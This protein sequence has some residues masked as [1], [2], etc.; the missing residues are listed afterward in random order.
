MTESQNQRCAERILLTYI[1]EEFLLPN[2]SIQVD[3]KFPSPSQKVPR[4]DLAKAK[5]IFKVCIVDD[6]LVRKPAVYSDNGTRMGRNECPTTIEWQGNFLNEKSIIC[7]TKFC[8]VPAA[9][10]PFF[11]VLSL[12]MSSVPLSQ[13]W[14]CS[15][16]IDYQYTPIITG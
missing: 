2:R 6:L 4:R 13:P 9:R 14:I 12:P 8:W 10:F 11:A 16:S 3:R 7:A 1:C 5:A 15:R